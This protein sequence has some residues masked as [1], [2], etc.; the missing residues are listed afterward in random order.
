ML[1]FFQ[2][3]FIVGVGLTILSFVFG[4][5]FDFLGVDG[6]DLGSLDISLPL[7]PMVYIL[8]TTTFGGLGWILHIIFPN[9]PSFL[10][11][12]ISLSVGIFTAGLFYKGIISPLHKA[13]NTSAPDQEEL[14][15]VIAMVVEKI[16]ENG[17]GEISYV[18]NG[19][20]YIA[21]AKS[22]DN[23]PIEKQADVSICWIEEYVFYV[24][25]L[26]KE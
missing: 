23:T 20:T 2:V 3:C 17:F 15:G 19:N 5:L 26:D 16:P 25:K 11:I 12:V 22:T 4:S 24:S 13:E 14:I 8:G 18:V 7:S 6:I 1:M 10:V 9:C 21:P